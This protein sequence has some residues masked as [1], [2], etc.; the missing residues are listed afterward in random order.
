MGKLKEKLLNKTLR[1]Y[2]YIS[3]LTFLVSAPIFYFLLVQ[4]SVQDTKNILFLHKKEFEKSYVPEIKE[5]DI[6]LWNK[7]N[8]NRKLGPLL[9][10]ST[11][12][13]IFT[14]VYYDSLAF[15]NK[16]Y[17]VLAGS[18]MI[19]NKPYA[20]LGKRALVE[21]E[22]LLKN[23]AFLFC[24]TISILLMAL[25]LITKR[26]SNKL[27]KPFYDTLEQIER[28]EIDK[29]EIRNLSENDIEEFTRLNESIN[30][31]IDRN[32]VIYKS[33]REF[34][35]NAAHEL[36]T[37]LAIFQSKFDTLIQRLDITEGQAI[38]LEKLHDGI[39]RLNRVNKNLLL[40]SKID[41][42]EYGIENVSL[43][44]IILKQLD[45]FSEQAEEKK[46]HLTF[47]TKK[48]IKIKSNETLTEV[49]VSNLILNAVRHNIEGGKI[50]ILLEHDSLIVSN[51]SANRALS[52]EKLF[53]RFAKSNSSTRGSGLGLSII[54]K[55]S[56][57]Y[58]WEVNYSFNENLHVFTVRFHPSTNSGQNLTTLIYSF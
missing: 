30:N 53:V 27:W 52:E 42:N 56:D 26:L 33:Q 25:Y 17:L 1:V 44:G 37:P 34:I 45:F 7:M 10:K 32:I 40:L 48:D 41:N 23:I 4:L 15:E 43:K 6:A 31:L 22:D 19:E 16:T 38:I 8:R 58:D 50:D 46:L 21:S 29:T 55:I 5:T 20:Y 49:L 13:S 54:K 14:K 3:L 24:G 36:Q 2:I 18:V 9:F 11:N 12:D 28:F 39:G 47:E 57:L 51:T 35:E